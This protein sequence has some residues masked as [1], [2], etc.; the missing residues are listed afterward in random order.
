MTAPQKPAVQ[1][2]IARALLLGV[3]AAGPVLAQ[4]AP[5]PPAA[6]SAP[7]AGMPGK[8]GGPHRMH[9]QQRGPMFPSMSEEGR[10]IMREAMMAGGDR[11]ENRAR[12]EA[13]REKMLAAV[14]ADRFDAAAVKR[15]MDEERA[16]SDASRQARQA[17]LLAAF[18]KLTPADRKAFAADSRAMKSRMEQRMQ[19]WRERM[20][21]RRGAP[22]APPAPSATPA[23]DADMMI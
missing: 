6:P 1:K 14:E 17:A 20:R 22:P 23:A 4:T 5:P 9:M 12:V 8:H 3:L 11:R 13:V 10:T 15:A 18:Q 19:G 7:A 16:L 2:L 21:E